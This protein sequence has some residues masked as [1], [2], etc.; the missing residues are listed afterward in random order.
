MEYWWLSSGYWIVL[1]AAVAVMTVLT[2]WGPKKSSWSWGM[3]ILLVGGGIWMAQALPAAER[4]EQLIEKRAAKHCETIRA[5]IQALEPGH[6]LGQAV[7]PL[8]RQWRQ[9]NSDISAA[10]LLYRHQAAGTA[11]EACRRETGWPGFGPAGGTRTENLPT[12]PNAS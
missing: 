10:W 9:D 1:G 12:K 3:G 5:N 8:L 4:G 2:L 11:L 7:I 6:P